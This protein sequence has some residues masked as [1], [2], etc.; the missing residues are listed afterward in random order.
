M[1]KENTATT[2]KPAKA[3][4]PKSLIVFISFDAEKA[5]DQHKRLD[6]PGTPENTFIRVKSVRGTPAE[7]QSKAKAK[8]HETLLGIVANPV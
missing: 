2:A 4:A 1:A 5:T 8:K 3:K 6:Y 7:A